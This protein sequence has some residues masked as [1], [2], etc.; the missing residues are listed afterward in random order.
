M[1][2]SAGLHY[3]VAP[4]GVAPLPIKSGDFRVE[5]L[6]VLASLWARLRLAFFFKKKKYLK[7][8]EFSLF[9]SRPKSGT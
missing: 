1:P 7:Y 2:Y 6:G 4:S 3:V 9:S 8:D 5:T